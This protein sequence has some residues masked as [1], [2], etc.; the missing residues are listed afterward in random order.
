MNL[1]GAGN[2]KVLS[3][4]GLISKLGYNSITHYQFVHLADIDR[5]YLDILEDV[6]KEYSN[7]NEK[8]PAPHFLHV[9]IGWDYNP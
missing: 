1:S 2:G 3:A 5:D 7:L 8:I 4:Y 6:K 9:S